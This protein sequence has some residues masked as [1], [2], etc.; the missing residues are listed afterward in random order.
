MHENAS[1]PPIRRCAAGEGNE[2]VAQA[3]RQFM[4]SPWRW[5]FAATISLLIYC[6]L[7]VLPV[8]GVVATMLLTPF[9]SVGLCVMARQP[10][11]L[12]TLGS[13][14]EPTVGIMDSCRQVCQALTAGFRHQS[15]PLLLVGG[16]L[17]V[18]STVV[19][20]LLY[21]VVGGAALVQLGPSIYSLITDPGNVS[22]IGSLVAVLPLLIT[23]LL[24]H[25]VWML[26]AGSALLFA[27]LLV[28]FDHQPLVPALKHSFSAVWRNVWPLTLASLWLGLA[29]LVVPLTFGLA[30]LAWLPL[31]MICFNL[32]AQAI[33][34]RRLENQAVRPMLT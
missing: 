30:L 9:W 18:C 7:L 6:V 8:V 32:A 34:G 13:F 20:G 31:A 12:V 3:F 15:G 21:L 16:V 28:Y 14:A 10:I 4:A 29:A 19:P 1:P 25:V 17:L 5:V 26:F 24:L 23:A 11:S 2:W 33:F 22:V 27:P